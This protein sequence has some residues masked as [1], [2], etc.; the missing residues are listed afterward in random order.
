MTRGRPRTFDRDT[1]VLEAARLFWRHG[2]SGTS[3]RALTAA[4]GLSP[5]S[6]YTAFGS[7]AGL[8]E[9]AVRTY[10]E[11]YRAIYADAV[12]APDLATVLERLLTGSVVEFTQPP[13]EHPGCLVSSAVLTD[14]PDTLDV[15]QQVTA[16]HD[17]LARMLRARV[18][19]A[20][21]DEELAPWTDPDTVTG[22]VQAV[23][24]GLSVESGRGIGRERLL[25]V[26]GLARE[27]LLA[28]SGS[29]A[30]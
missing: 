24:H 14:S 10:A 12:T 19:Q 15:R 27:S 8:F 16:L 25:A 17:D 29:R 7:K 2:Y 3:T 22:L 20:V 11:R 9:E 23:W 21:A 13:A 4:L 28:G 5:S 18:A 1:A 6:L 26:A 30:G